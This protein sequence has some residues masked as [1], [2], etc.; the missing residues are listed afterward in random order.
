MTFYQSDPIMFT[1]LRNLIYRFT[2]E[3]RPN[4]HKNISITWIRYPN[5]N[6]KPNS[7][8]GASWAQNQIFYPA[9]VVKLIYGIATEVWLQKDLI[10]ESEE[11]RRAVSDMIIYSSNDATSYVVDVLTGSNS[12][13]CLRGKQLKS[14]RLQR[15]L[16][17]QWL[18]SLCWPELK[19]SNCCQKT[20]GDGPY[21]RDKDFYGKNNENR[22]ALCTAAAAR[23]LET[24]M[25]EN[26]LAP[27]RSK[28]L[29]SYFGRSLDLIDRKKDPD[30]QIDGFLGEGLPPETQFWSK[31]GWMSEVRHDA[32]WWNQPGQPSMLLVVFSKGKEL[33]NDKFL[34]P[35]L[36][37]ELNQLHSS[38]N[39]N[40]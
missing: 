8:I 5:N 22:N 7:G 13:P 12:G 35:A 21:G 32:A 40:S 29:Q 9:S 18:K 2:K 37:N 19:H 39:I 33:S 15:Q 31:A 24:L 3:G 30:N 27:K 17:N 20:W 25:T 4:L 23:F 14:W 34:L 38:L 16:I 36:A 10:L 28:V 26:F 11:L 1:Y 6:P